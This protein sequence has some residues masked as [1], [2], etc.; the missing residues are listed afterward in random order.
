MRPTPTPGT[1]AVASHSFAR[2][3]AQRLCEDFA[4]STELRQELLKG[5][6]PLTSSL[7]RTR[8]TAELQQRLQFVCGQVDRATVTRQA[9]RFP[10]LCRL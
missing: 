8:S 7:P 3:S 1:N 9:V 4:G 6:E 5:I 10:S 2:R